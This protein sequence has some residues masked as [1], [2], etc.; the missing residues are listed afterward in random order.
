MSKSVSSLCSSNV[1]P[2]RR[3]KS[4][5]RGF[6]GASWRLFVLFLGLGTDLGVPRAAQNAPSFLRDGAL[7]P[8]EGPGRLPERLKSAPRASKRA[9]RGLQERPKSAPR[10][11]KSTLRAPKRA[12]R[13]PQERPR[14]PQERP[15][16]PKEPKSA[17]KAIQQRPE[18]PREPSR[19][20]FEPPARKKR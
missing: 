14:A 12:P 20:H 13:A 7:D 3:P 6:L 8:H 9:P 10:A 11:T 17:P 19:H 16:A 18:I 2:K 15:R 1:C 4:A 5:L